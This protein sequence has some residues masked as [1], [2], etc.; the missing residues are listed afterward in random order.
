MTEPLVRVGSGRLAR[1]RT[2]SAS[3]AA[4]TEPV[5]NG[6][7]RG[8]GR[9]E[10]LIVSA[11][12]LSTTLILATTVAVTT[13][14]P[15]IGRDTQASEAQLQWIGDSY[16]L[17]LAALLLPAGL[18]LDRFGRRRGLIV[19]LSLLAAGLVWSALATNA[20][21]L[22]ASRCLSG[23]GGALAFPATLATITTFV[24][25]A[26]RTRAIALWSAS[27]VFGGIVG[28]VLTAAVN[29]LWWWGSTLL[30]LAGVIAACCALVVVAVPESR[31]PSW[32][33]LDVPGSLLSIGGIGLLAF[34]II[35]GPTLGW[36]DP[37]IL[38]STAIATML[39]LHFVL[40]ELRSTQP[41][42]DVRL[43]A[44]REVGTASLVVLV[45]FFQCFGSLF[46][47]IYYCAF[48]LGHATLGSAL[49][50]TPAGAV[51]ATALMSPFLAQRF[52]RRVIY[53]GGLGVV[54]FGLAWMAVMA[55]GGHGYW[56]I[57]I[58]VALVGAGAGP[59]VTT[60]TQRIVEALPG[61][62][63]GVA[64]A[65]N[66]TAR[67]LGAAVGIAVVG[68]A[69]NGGYRASIGG[70]R[71]ELAPGFVDE[72]ARGPAVGLQAAAALDQ[73]GG[74]ALDAV[75]D[76]AAAGIGHGFAIAGVIAAST[77][78]AVLYRLR[79]SQRGRGSSSPRAGA[80]HEQGE[81]RRADTEAEPAFGGG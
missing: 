21:L 46:L 81:D 56:P 5:S 79:D 41:L 60:A 64:S 17:V 55:P 23:A 75:R 68:S 66:D 54:T 22:I 39:L 1:V 70:A 31:D 47:G 9:R 76:A 26:R 18:L 44:D 48:V 32:G 52:R 67:E 72:A 37:T 24:P 63:Q 51:V 7:A 78:V 61:S 59:A 3:T 20:P 74:A 77:A 65:L 35:D 19:G 57:G 58:G 10:A 14:L 4:L 43:L 15:E 8:A 69:F 28:V 49:G 80:V 45:V 13:L 36:T 42:I 11:T 50:I 12:C 6:P 73:R 38:A 62:E 16:T 30:V 53:A 71:G 29:E 27:T 25:V 33:H 40:W 2:L 34:A